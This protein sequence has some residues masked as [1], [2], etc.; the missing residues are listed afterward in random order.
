MEAVESYAL[1]TL[2]VSRTSTFMAM[3]YKAKRDI[4]S[5]HFLKLIR[6]GNV[7]FRTLALDL[8]QSFG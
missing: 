8:A 2:Y 7:P 6:F 3:P 5:F 4:K 1:H